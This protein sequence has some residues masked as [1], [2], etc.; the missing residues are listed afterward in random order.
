MNNGTSNIIQNTEADND[1][2]IPTT[3]EKLNTDDIINK[4]TEYGES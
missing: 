3:K 1:D 4:L 2:T